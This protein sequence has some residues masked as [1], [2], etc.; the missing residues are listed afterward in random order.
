MKCKYVVCSVYF[1]LI[2][3]VIVHSVNVSFHQINVLTTPSYSFKKVS[4]T[5]IQTINKQIASRETS[6][7]HCRMESL[8]QWKRR[9]RR[10]TR[11]VYKLNTNSGIPNIKSYLFIN[12]ST[13]NKSFAKTE[14]KVNLKEKEIMEHNMLLEK[15]KINWPVQTWI[16]YGT[17]SEDYLSLINT[18]WMRFD[19]P[20]AINNYVLG[21]FYIIFVIV[22]C[23]GNAIVIILYARSV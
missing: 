10:L 21:G 1:L 20:P 15:F 19:P 4:H 23:S 12:E 22:G 3:S 14:L 9:R 2:V 13:N 5:Q 6:I 7:V 18:H 11:N 16:D 8:N 17:F